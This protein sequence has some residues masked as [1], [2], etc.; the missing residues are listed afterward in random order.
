M[1][2]NDWLID[3]RK[4][5]DHHDRAFLEILRVAIDSFIKLFHSGDDLAFDRFRSVAFPTQ[6]NQALPESLIKGVFDRTRNQ[7][8]KLLANMPD[9]DVPD[10]WGADLDTQTTNVLKTLLM[11]LES[12]FGIVNKVAWIKSKIGAQPV[13]SERWRLMR[14][15]LEE[16]S[17]QVGVEK[18]F[19]LNLFDFIHDQSVK[20]Q[21]KLLGQINES[22]EETIAHFSDSESLITAL[23]ES[24]SFCVFKF[25][26]DKSA[27]I[28]TSIYWDQ[29]IQSSLKYGFIFAP[30]DCASHPRHVLPHNL[31]TFD[32]AILRKTFSHLKKDLDSLPDNRA[33]DT[34]EQEYHNNIKTYLDS[35]AHKNGLDKVV[36]SGVK[37]LQGEYSWQSLYTHFERLC[38]KYPESF[39]YLFHHPKAGTWLGSS[40]ELLL[41][42][43]Q[44]AVRSMALAATKQVTDLADW[45]PKEQSE[46]NY[47]KEFIIN[48]FHN[49]GLTPSLG[50]FDLAHA[51][52]DIK[53]MMLEIMSEAPKDLDLIK[54][55]ENLHPNPAICGYPVSDS[56]ARILSS[57]LHGREYYSGYFGVIG[58]QSLIYTN[59]R[60]AR[61]FSNRAKL[62]AGAGITEGSILDSEWIEVNNKMNI[63]RCV[64]E[65]V[66]IKS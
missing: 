44:G 48:V 23:T 11:L 31:G 21:I 25:P 51:S 55:I 41:S 32:S 29:A 38:E 20:Y 24:A 2:N 57:E 61:M 4:D 37:H 16:Y 33:H 9:G 58:K 66:D 18:D 43:D 28:F 27:R 39:S 17:T 30:F 34:T 45:S 19:V 8:R 10:N 54:L 35:D 63:I 7:A 47:V 15:K 62:Y 6:K 42:V 49:N 22:P 46:F 36:L 60:C 56:K 64:L 1:S 13:D 40:P 52:G 5:I 14:K 53:H 26:D 12:R 3:A 50:E 59:L 65:N